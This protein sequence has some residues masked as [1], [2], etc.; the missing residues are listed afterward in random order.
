MDHTHFS[1][2]TTFICPLAHEPCG[3]DVSLIGHYAPLWF[4]VPVPQNSDAYVHALNTTLTSNVLPVTKWCWTFMVC[5]S[6]IGRAVKSKETRPITWIVTEILMCHPIIICASR[7]FWSAWR[8][9]AWPNTSCRA[10]CVG[11]YFR[12]CAILCVP[13]FECD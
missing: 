12:V 4:I 11:E 6:R 7:E 2:S 1:D 8:S 9:V 13:S 5:G 10:Y 3:I